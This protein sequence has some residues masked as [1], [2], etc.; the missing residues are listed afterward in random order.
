MPAVGALVRT[1]I[2]QLAPLPASVPPTSLRLVLPAASAAPPLSVSV[3]PQ[4]LVMVV[5][6]SVIAP[7]VVGKVSVKVTPLIA[8]APF[9][10]GFVKVSD[11]VDGPFGITGLGANDL[12]IVAGVITS[13]GAVLLTAPAAAPVCVVVTPLLVLL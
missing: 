1:V 4:P 2:T 11:S 7:G 13:S 5:S 12:A 9:A 10:A 3:P 8:F 6:A